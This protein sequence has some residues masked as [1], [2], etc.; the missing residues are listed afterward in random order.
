MLFITYFLFS[1]D[2]V[3]RLALIDF[4]LSILLTRVSL[5]L[6]IGFYTRSTAMVLIQERM[7]MEEE[8]VD[9]LTMPMP[10]YNF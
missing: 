6:F 8:D 7:K 4:I 10:M 5:L 2:T 3:E 1:N 9:E